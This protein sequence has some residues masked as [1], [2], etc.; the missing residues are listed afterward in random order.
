MT[1]VTAK[2]STLD[3]IALMTHLRNIVKYLKQQKIYGTLAHNI[4]DEQAQGLENVAIAMYH[5]KKDTY[6]KLVDAV[7]KEIL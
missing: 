5:Q 1:T 2:K 3:E 4:Y 6:C 7:K